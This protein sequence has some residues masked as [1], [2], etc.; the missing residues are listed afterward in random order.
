MFL[1]MKTKYWTYIFVFTKKR[2]MRLLPNKTI[3]KILSKLSLK[4]PCPKLKTTS[5]DGIKI[6][7]YQT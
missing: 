1:V 4:F 7:T 5:D 6:Q 3:F 2:I